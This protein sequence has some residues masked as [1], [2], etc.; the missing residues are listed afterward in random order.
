METY[1]ELR[2]SLETKFSAF[3]PLM[4]KNEIRCLTKDDAF[5]NFVNFEDALKALD[6]C[7]KKEVKLGN[8]IIFA[9]ARPSVRYIQEIQLKLR[10]SG[11]TG[12]TFQEAEKTAESI[13]KKDTPDLYLVLLDMC[14]SL[15]EIDWN[16]RV[17]KSK[18]EEQP[19]NS[20]IVIPQQVDH[21]VAAN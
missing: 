21:S 14:E 16:K 3:G 12:M 10:E 2:S 15:F 4:P 6:K 20:E 8:L 18:K 1:N 5:V 7:S 19:E 17:V 13:E 9:Q 11:K